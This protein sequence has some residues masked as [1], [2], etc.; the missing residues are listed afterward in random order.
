MSR[1]L[2]E[3]SEALKSTRGRSIPIHVGEVMTRDVVT[4]S[5]QHS[6]HEA[7]ALIARYR[8]RHLVVADAEKCLVGVLSDRDLLRFMVREP[9]WDATTV[10]EVMKTDPQTVRADTLL[11]TATAEMLTQRINCLPVV[12]EHGRVEGIVTSTDLL[13]A[14]HNVQEQLEHLETANLAEQNTVPSATGK[15]SG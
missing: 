11:S 6:F 15:E 12:N 14:F 2:S 1:T 5:P 9:R 4:L 8:F 13:R 3:L 7:I 10:A